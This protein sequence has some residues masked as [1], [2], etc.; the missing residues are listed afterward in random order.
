MKTAGQVAA[1]LLF[2]TLIGAFSVWPS[3]RL[4]QPT[5]AMISVTFSH[6]GQRVGECRQLTQDEMNDLP[7]NM[8]RPADCPRE[9][10]PVFVRFSANNKV[11]FEDS[12]R[13]S[14]IWEDGKSNLYRRL[15]LDAGRYSL[16]LGMND[17]GGTSTAGAEQHVDVDLK[18]GQN[19][20]I[21]FNEETRQFYLIQAR[22]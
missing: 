9:R 14:G 6:A 1:Y 19:L 3:F 7:P 15:K 16:L 17:S 2:A 20:V 8:R 5:E 4:L 22:P 21:G 12:L 10:H 18:P 11:L 13:P